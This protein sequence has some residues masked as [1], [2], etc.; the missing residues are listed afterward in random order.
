MTVIDI[1]PGGVS[2][3]KQSLWRLFS[4]ASPIHPQVYAHRLA[5][6]R[7]IGRQGDTVPKCATFDNLGVLKVVRD[8]NRSLFVVGNGNG[9]P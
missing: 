1:P 5:N 3:V 9:L 7:R 4:V 8:G 6:A 2:D